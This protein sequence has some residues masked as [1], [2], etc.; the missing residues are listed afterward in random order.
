MRAGLIR[1]TNRY[2]KFAEKFKKYDCEI[3]ELD[4]ADP[5]WIFS[6]FDSM[7]FLIYFPS[8]IGTSNRPDSL[9]RVKNS[10]EFIH[11][12]F[13]VLPIF[14]DPNLYRFY[15]DKYEQYL[16]LTYQKFP[17]PKTTVLDNSLQISAIGENIGFPCVVKNRY[18]AG[19]DYVFLVKSEDELSSLL[20]FANLNF[21]DWRSWWRALTQVFRRDFLRGFATGRTAAY[22][23]LSLPLI[24]QEFI[25]HRSDLKLVVGDFEV[26]EGHWRHSVSSS[27]WKMN[28]DGGGAGEWSHIP[29]EVL[30]LGIRLSRSLGAKW[31]NIDIIF[32][33]NKPLISEFSPVW[34]HY[35]YKEQD[36]FVYKSDYNLP[37]SAEKAADLEELIV[38]SFVAG[39][40]HLS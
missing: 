25:Y 23:F 10:L 14:P 6:D 3:I 19:G 26:K 31:L 1:S 33:D 21:S 38:S 18:G 12:Q 34:H 4:F 24:V 8:F 7:D 35:R 39:S 11:K 2:E 16:Y 15:G 37:I 5:D 36:T 20:N 17:I 30:D 13:P 22:P 29:Q 28:I 27:N 40:G 9:Y 32:S